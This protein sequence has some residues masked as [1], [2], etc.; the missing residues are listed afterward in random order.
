M[1][2]FLRFWGLYYLKNPSQ[3]FLVPRIELNDIMFFLFGI[4][5][6][7]TEDFAVGMFVSLCYIY[8]QHPSSGEKLHTVARRL[9]LWLWR[10]GIGTLVFSARGHFNPELQAWQ[11]FSRLYAY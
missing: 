7:Y 2:L 10:G 3:S 4:T 9:T 11:F 8:A 1:G 5:G 6:K